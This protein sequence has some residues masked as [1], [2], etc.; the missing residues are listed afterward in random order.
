MGKTN[1]TS[2]DRT[3]TYTVESLDHGKISEAGWDGIVA[4]LNGDFT[5]S[6]A[7]SCYMSKE[8]RQ[9][10]RY[11]IIR[12]AGRAAAAGWYVISG[13]SIGPA[14]FLKS[15]SMETLP[16]HDSE[17]IS[18]QDVFREVYSFAERERCVTFSFGNS[19]YGQTVFPAGSSIN[20]KITFPIDL[21]KP[22]EALMKD[23]HERHR[24]RIR[25]AEK[26]ALRARCVSADEARALAGLLQG[27]FEYTFTRQTSTGKEPGRI[28]ITSFQNIIS[29]LA[30]RRNVLI[31]AA[32][33]ENEPVCCYIAAVF[34][35]NAKLLYGAS[36]AKGYELNA[37]FL[38]LWRMIEHFREHHYRSLSLGEV[39][40]RSEDPKDL[41]HGL[42]RYK[43]GFSK[44]TDVL[45]AGMIIMRPAAYAVMAVV[46]NLQVAIGNRTRNRNMVIQRVADNEG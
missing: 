4:G 31:F 9:A 29:E 39:P 8:L 5:H 3:R 7:W 1:C 34:N 18:E 15:F 2:I 27:L 19:A 24:A 26:S 45:R 6:Y 36:N 17:A 37:S 11:L 10:P 13:K 12:H 28:G 22:A 44:K 23:F 16:C 25:K 20:E 42:Y 35:G 14:R 32:F 33:L 30:V 21:R 40:R 46:K 41:D 43:L 38:V